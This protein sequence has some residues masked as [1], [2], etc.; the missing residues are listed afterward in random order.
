MKCIHAL[1]RI[2]ERDRG[3][4]RTQEVSL[5]A[6]WDDSGEAK[7]QPGRADSGFSSVEARDLAATLSRDLSEGGG[8]FLGWCDQI[9]RG[10][11]NQDAFA[12]ISKDSGASPVRLSKILNA[13]RREACDLLRVKHG[14]VGMKSS[15]VAGFD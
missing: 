4:Y 11:S 1:S 3:K 12:Q 2:Y 5:D 7:I 13:T 8:L 15:F 14:L 9:M 10:R 6:S